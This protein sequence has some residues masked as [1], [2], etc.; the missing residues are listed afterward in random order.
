MKDNISCFGKFIKFFI[1]FSYETS[2][3]S[4]QSSFDKSAFIQINVLFTI[5]CR[6]QN[7]L[8]KLPDMLYYPEQ[9][10]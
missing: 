3:L 2:F 5:F 9:N 7:Y 10:K 1:I 4:M 6:K 8:K